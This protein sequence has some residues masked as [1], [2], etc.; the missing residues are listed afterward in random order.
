MSLRRAV[1]VTLLAASLTTLSAACGRQQP[2][3][4]APPSDSAGG[5]PTTSAPPSGSSSPSASASSSA[6]SSASAVF[7]LVHLAT[8]TRSVPDVHTVLDSEGDLAR[9]PGYF[10]KSAPEIAKAI[11]AKASKT[12]FSRNVLVGWSRTTGCS[13]ATDAALFID[14]K[15]RLFLGI[16]Q[17]QPLPECFAANHVVTV[18]EVPR[19]SLPDNPRFAQETNEKA[20]PPGPGRTVAFTKLDRVPDGATTNER[21]TD[22][23]RTGELNAFLSQLSRNGAAT[24]RKQ[25]A[26]HP[27]LHGERRIAYI[28]S[29]CRP[30]GAALL[31]SPGLTTVSAV[32][33]GDEN[34]RCLR[35]QHYAAVIAVAG[36][37]LPA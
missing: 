16:Q 3:T 1:S 32:P 36:S 31:I 28:L 21:G 13:A 4:G 18:F 6:S 22:V 34:I 2:A 14:A 35:A 17:P 26:A 10:A 19:T 5:G 29:S 11:T 30:T 12:D 24:V 27:A 8:T 23:T 37:L 25:L 33:T 20:D 9:F 7:R 15:Q